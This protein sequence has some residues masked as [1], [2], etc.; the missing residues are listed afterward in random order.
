MHSSW[1][2]AQ[3]NTSASK[4]SATFKG[5]VTILTP[6]SGCFLVLSA[7]SSPSAQPQVETLCLTLT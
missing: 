1:H 2:N 5:E 4:T 7:L 3:H 6:T